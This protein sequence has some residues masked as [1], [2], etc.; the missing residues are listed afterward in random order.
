M[1]SSFYNAFAGGAAYATC[2][3][4][5]CHLW[6]LLAPAGEQGEGQGHPV[7]CLFWLALPSNISLLPPSSYSSSSSLSIP[8]AAKGSGA[9]GEGRGGEERR[10]GAGGRWGR[11]GRRG[12]ERIALPTLHLPVGGR[13]P[14]GSS[15]RTSESRWA[16]FRPRFFLQEWRSRSLAPPLLHVTQGSPRKW[17]TARRQHSSEGCLSRR[18]ENILLFLPSPGDATPFF[19]FYL[20]T[21]ISVK[22]TSLVTGIHA[23][24]R[25]ITCGSNSNQGDAR[26]VSTNENEGF[27]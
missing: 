14:R 4:R 8:D 21:L 24:Q 7:S 26:S 20:F 25:G 1:S 15:C 16:P 11:W 13:V 9:G 12:E 5:R 18:F 23:F 17:W 3:T 22:L 10:R 2:L 27:G 6:G 19:F